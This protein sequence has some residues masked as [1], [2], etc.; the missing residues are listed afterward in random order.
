MERWLNN[1]CE[2]HSVLVLSGCYNKIPQT[3]WLIN[4]RSLFLTVLEAGE[5]KI[6]VPAW[7]HC[8]ESPLPGSELVPF[9]YVL[10]WWKGLGVSLEPVL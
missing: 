3:G 8:G 7:S 6:K 1:L 9:C 5:S 10:I 2:C 4:N